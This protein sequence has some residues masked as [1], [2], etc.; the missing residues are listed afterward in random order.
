MEI[1]DSSLMLLTKMFGDEDWFAKADYD[2]Y[3]RPVV[4]VHRLSLEIGLKVPRH[5]DGKQVL[6]HFASS[7]PASQSKFV[8]VEVLKPVAQDDDLLADEPEPVVDIDVLISELDRLER[9]CGSN[10]LQDIFYEVHDGKN[11]VTNL[12]ARFPDVRE[13][14]EALYDEYGFDIV[15][16]ELD[17]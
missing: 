2:Q 9:V 12:S 4:Y 1:S 7:L 6:V 13:D 15:Y 16:E 11:A 10:I 17:G 8:E 3:G 14:V 5:I